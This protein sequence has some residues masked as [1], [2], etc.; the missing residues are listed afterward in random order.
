MI[1]RYQELHKH[2]TVFK[3]L[4]GL[5]VSEFDTLVDELLPEYEQAEEE[6]LSRPD[7]LRAIGGGPTFALNARHR[8]IAA[9]SYLVKKV[10]DPGSIGLSIWRER[11]QRWAGGQTA[12]TPVGTVGAGDNENA[13]SGPETTTTV[14]RLI[15]GHPLRI[16]G[17]DRHL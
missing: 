2:E 1:G 11:Y 3:A 10:S 17:G 8:P 9:D 15:G 5:R 12:V 6:R 7:R 4:T 16:G 14:V 13:G